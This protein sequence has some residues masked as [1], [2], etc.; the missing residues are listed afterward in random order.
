[1]TVGWPD[2]S[3]TFFYDDKNSELSLLCMSG[4]VRRPFTAD[5]G[6]TI[7]RRITMNQPMGNRLTHTADN[8]AGETDSNTA[9][10]DRFNGTSPA[11]SS[12]VEDKIY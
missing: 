11:G 6:R 3:V 4:F 5:N 1:M 8:P 2:V 9:R 12:A 10:Y 7:F